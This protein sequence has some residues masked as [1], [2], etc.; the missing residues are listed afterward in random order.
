M[1]NLFSTVLDGT[2]G[3]GEGKLT[4]HGRF[5]VGEVLVFFP[6]SLLTFLVL[7]VSSLLS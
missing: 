3:E 2:V 6:L 1:M 4:L 5:S 7:L